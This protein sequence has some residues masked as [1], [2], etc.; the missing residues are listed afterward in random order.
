MKNA[1]FIILLLNVSLEC[2]YYEK[3]DNKYFQACSKLLKEE[4]DPLIQLQKLAK[5]QE[6][7]RQ[8]KQKLKMV[9][10]THEQAKIEM[11]ETEKKSLSS[12]LSYAFITKKNLSNTHISSICFKGIK[13][14]EEKIKEE[15]KTKRKEIL[16]EIEAS[17]VYDGKR[18]L[19]HIRNERYYMNALKKLE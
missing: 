1:F 16:Q 3:K 11:Q 13:T 18:K 9:K 15:K 2:S 12:Q 10:W 6:T 7:K 4:S 19:I 5:V 8:K 17:K 14:I